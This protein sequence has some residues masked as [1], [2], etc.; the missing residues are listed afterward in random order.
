MENKFRQFCPPTLEKFWK[1]PLVAPLEKILLTPMLEAF[2]KMQITRNQPQMFHNRRI[3]REL[4][5]VT[6]TEL[7]SKLIR[8]TLVF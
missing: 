3:F 1:N 8:Q 5:N 2:V 6:L 7:P 4:N